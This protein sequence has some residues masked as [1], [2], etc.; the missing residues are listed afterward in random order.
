MWWKSGS[1]CFSSKY[2]DQGQRFEEPSLGVCL[3]AHVCMNVIHYV[4]HSTQS[5]LKADFFVFVWLTHT[6]HVY[7]LHMV[8]PRK[9]QGGCGL[10]CMDGWMH[11][12]VQFR[13]HMTAY[14]Q[15]IIETSVSSF[16]QEALVTSKCVSKCV[17]LFFEAWFLRG[18]CGSLKQ[19]PP[20]WYFACCII[21]KWF[22]VCKHLHLSISILYSFF[23]LLLFLLLLY[24]Q[25]LQFFRK[26]YISEPH[27]CI[28]WDVFPVS[29]ILEPPLLRYHHYNTKYVFIYSW[30]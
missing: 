21:L 7:V 29:W 26:I 13:C 17:Y 20:C 1:C 12:I 9:K 30:K 2:T 8:F 5:R 28:V 16:I 3:H 4:E 15:N 6:V 25:A 14:I 11:A 18:R 10:A 24:F 22:Y 23:V 27:C 19:C